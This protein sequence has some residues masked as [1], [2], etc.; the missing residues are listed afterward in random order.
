MSDQN[1]TTALKVDLSSVPEPMRSMLL[2]QLAKIP[3]PMREKL[4]S[5]GSPLLDRMIAKARE[6]AGASTAAVPASVAESDPDGVDRNTAD[7]AKP[8]RI[9]TVRNNSGT[10]APGRI[11]TVSPGDSASSGM[12]LLVSAIAL[13]GAVWYALYA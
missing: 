3:A 8:D 1:N 13:I 6:H 4:L 11:Q 10:S 5:E 2:K 7:R 9:Q 12:W